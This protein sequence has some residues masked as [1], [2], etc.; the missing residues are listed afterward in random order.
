MRLRRLALACGLAV[1]SAACAPGLDAEALEEEI[2][3]GL[4]EQTGIEVASV[5]CPRAVE[6]A[7]GTTFECLAEADGG[8]IA[9]SVR[10]LDSEGRKRWRFTRGLIKGLALEDQIDGWLRERMPGHTV[11][12]DCGRGY[13]VATPGATFTCTAESDTGH[14]RELRVTIDDELG[15]VSWVLE[16]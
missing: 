13:R 4:A 5:R 10:L 9:V 6:L 12:V 2:G 7:P 8:T 16:R 3:E 14:A 15:N 1:G 11:W